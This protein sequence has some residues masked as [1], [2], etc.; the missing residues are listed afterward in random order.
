MPYTRISVT[1]WS[2]IDVVTS[3][4]IADLWTRAV[5]NKEKN[6]TSEETDAV[7]QI[8]TAVYGTKELFKKLITASA[9]FTEIEQRVIDKAASSY[10]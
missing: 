5:I 2:R 7:Q 8:G 3:F 6:F 4:L 1:E 9:D 10:I